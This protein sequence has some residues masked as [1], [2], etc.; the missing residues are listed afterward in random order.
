MSRDAIIAK[1]EA[2]YPCEIG[3]KL[4]NEIPHR[5]VIGNASRYYYRK[6]DPTLKNERPNVAP[7]GFNCITDADPRLLYIMMAASKFMPSGWQIHSRGGPN[8]DEFSDQ[9]KGETI[10]GQGQGT[11]LRANGS[12]INHFCGLAIDVCIQIN[13]G[14]VLCNIRN[15]R[16]FRT[17]EYLYQVIC[18]LI[19][20]DLVTDENG[21]RCKWG[22]LI[23]GR[24]DENG[25]TRTTEMLGVRRQFEIGE[26]GQYKV[27]IGQDGT[28][29]RT[30]FEYWSKND[31]GIEIRH[32]T[33]ADGS[34]KM[35]TDRNGN[36]VVAD[37]DAFVQRSAP[38]LGLR[39]GGY[40]GDSGM[41]TEEELGTS[42]KQKVWQ[43]EGAPIAGTAIKKGE[44]LKSGK[45]IK[46]TAADNR[47]DLY[48]IPAVDELGFRAERRVYVKGTDRLVEPP[49]YEK[50]N[51]PGFDNVAWDSMHYDFKPL[52]ERFSISQRL[53]DL[54]TIPANQNPSEKPI[55][56]R[57]EPLSPARIRAMELPAT[58]G[59]CKVV[60]EATLGVAPPPG[61]VAK[62]VP[63]SMLL[64]LPIEVPAAN[65][66]NGRLS[67][68]WP[69]PYNDP[70]GWRDLVPKVTTS[71]RTPA[72]R[73][74][75]RRRYRGVK[76]R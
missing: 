69:A 68:Q 38:T 63:P 7:K 49:V 39:W 17:Y 40:F 75:N 64:P 16:S 31:D 37:P 59:D 6:N 27:E 19:H 73:A 32:N 42:E 70:D 65:E 33:N 53:I 13:D 76:P 35:K 22:D 30:K 57:T 36:Q 45:L 12:T 67:T 2:D 56:V 43:H 58:P 54:L 10:K 72:E 47:F 5:F 18:N 41:Y 48:P 20:N 60:W 11:L 61:F 28:V 71:T 74:R 62:A 55:P 51:L 23:A 3:T 9:G 52:G 50:Y 21:V 34:V 46:Y 15:H 25:L 44:L 8:Q 29:N 66:G 24:L 1:R 14:T 26:D 4:L